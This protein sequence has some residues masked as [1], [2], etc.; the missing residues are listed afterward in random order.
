M[1]A[2]LGANLDQDCINWLTSAPNYPTAG[3]LADFF[4]AERSGGV[5]IAYFE[6]TL[7]DPSKVIAA[8]TLNVAGFN[9]L[10]N[11]AGA[12]F[13]KNLNP[14][15]ISN[16]NNGT[17]RFQAFTLLHEFA[18]QL[19]VPGFYSEGD[20]GNQQ[21]LENLNNQ[22]IFDHCNKTLASFSNGML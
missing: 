21:A 3:K 5:G 12:Y 22:M 1:I 19:G 13:A 8:A 11:T 16:L 2:S 10:I 15:G 9:I 20:T 7:G 14:S 18:H 17:D 6:D 4:L